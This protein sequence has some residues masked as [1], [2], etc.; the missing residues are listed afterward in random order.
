MTVLPCHAPNVPL[1]SRSLLLPVALLLLAGC[2]GPSA[3]PEHVWGRH[4]VQPGDLH[5][6][7]AVAIDAQDH[8]YIV[9]FTARVQ[10]YDPDG[11]YLHHGWT[12]PDYRNGRP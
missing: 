1:P 10:V 11:N 9:D 7:R 2:T 6:P 12:T 5:R 8:L 3:E 4:G